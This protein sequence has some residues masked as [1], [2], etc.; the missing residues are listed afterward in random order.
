MFLHCQR[1]CCAVILLLMVTS[2]YGSSAA[3][4]DEGSVV[5][6]VPKVPNIQADMDI[7][8][9]LDESAWREALTMTMDYESEPGENLPAKVKTRMY[10]FED[11]ATLYVAF[12][13][14]DPDP[15]KIRAYLRERDAIWNDDY[16]GVLIDPFNDSRR[17]YGFAVSAV[18]VQ[19]DLLRNED[20][21]DYD[22]SWDAI[23]RSAAQ[24]HDNGYTAEFAI[25]LSQFRFPLS[26]GEQ[27][28]R[29]FGTRGY[30]R[31]QGYEFSTFPVHR[32]IKCK[33]CQY[34]EIRGFA[35][36][37]P[38]RD[39]QIVPTVTVIRSDVADENWS[40]STGK[41]AFDEGVSV[42]W[43]LT[44]DI[45]A[46]FA[47][48][49][50]FSQVESDVG[51]LDINQQF[52]LQ[53]PEK[54]PFFLEGSDYFSTPVDAVFTRTIVDPRYGA[55][56][57]GRRDEHTFGMFVAEDEVTNLLFPGTYSSDTGAIDSRSRSLVA[58]YNYNFGPANAGAL[59]TSRDGDGYRNRVGAIDGY[60]SLTEQDTF[61]AQYLHSETEYPDLLAV[62]H[63][64]PL[65]SF[66]GYGVA[67]RYKHDGEYWSWF[68][69][70]EKYDDN[71]RADSGFVP[72]VGY[73]WQMG[74]FSRR[75]WGDDGMW[76]NSVRLRADWDISHD[77]TGQVK[78]RAAELRL[79]VNGAYSSEFSVEGGM[80]RELW[81]DVLYEKKGFNFNASMKP[82]SGLF[83][84]VHG[85]V[86]DQI[87]YSNARLADQ[88]WLRPRAEWNVNKNLFMGVDYT[89]S[90]LD[91]KMGPNIYDAQLIDARLTWHFN[92]RSFVR[93]TLQHQNI[94]RNQD[95]YTEI[96]TPHYRSNGLQFLYSYKL[97]PQTVFFLGYA[98]NHIDDNDLAN[99]VLTDRT[100][101]MKIGYAWMPEASLFN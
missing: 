99:N 98:D 49:P 31:S 87:D 15:S 4:G 19:A 1:L 68:T 83:L 11:G 8:G 71:F 7:D 85:S 20:V 6:S 5:P 92:I 73:D 29:I 84:E 47:L 58:R 63:G 44:P 28:W 16:I 76:W 55:K 27:I 56:V 48:N 57:T 24:I 42:R 77:S 72:T 50:D 82:L 80:G 67:A 52:A 65:G 61:R 54:R 30:P 38:T 12:E 46:S 43:G 35:D 33:I 10:L 36:A 78:G 91:S 45:T 21:D 9:R 60:W 2:S 81:K 32:D 86:G 75:W 93:A 34:Q 96:V 101:F 18:G 39:L 95:E 53:Y 41:P 14:D 22:D 79:S 64:Q 89:V 17:A 13:A 23:W 69:M 74:G 97:N 62:E 26:S 90:K 94:R 100:F 88:L 59:I 25:P 66:S 3:L 37:K 70:Y 40:L 51:Q